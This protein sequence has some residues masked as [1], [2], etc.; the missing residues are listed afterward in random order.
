MHNRH[1]LTRPAAVAFATALALVAVTAVAWDLDQDLSTADGALI[2]ESGSDEAGFHVVL[3]GDLDG[4]GYADLVIAA[5]AAEGID[6]N[7][8]RV[9]VYLGAVGAWAQA[10]DIGDADASFLGENYNDRA[11]H[12]L[13]YAGDVNGDGYDDLLI[14]A[15]FNDEA[16]NSFGQAYLILGDPAGWALDTDLG[17]AD[18][19][20]HG[21]ANSDNAGEAVAG[22]GDVDG[23]GHD[24]LLIAAPS[25][26]VAYG[27]Q[28]KVYLVTGRASGW[29]D[30]RD[31]GSYADAS[32]YGEADGDYA[33]ISL[34]SAGDV[35][36]D[37]YDDVLIGAYWNDE[38][39]SYA[40]QV[41]L[42]LGSAAGFSGTTNLEYSD[43]SFLGENPD[44]EAGTAVAGAGDV[45]SD[46]YDD[47]LIGAPGAS[48]AG[49]DAGEAY[50][51][52]GHA[53]GWSMDTDLSLADASFT[54]EA[55]DD[56][57]GTD[58]AA[59][60]DTNLDGHD[61]FLVG[62]PWN[63]ENGSGAGQVY[64]LLGR[65]GSWTLH[66]DLAAEAE[67]TWL[68]ELAGDQAGT[69]VGGNGDVDAD[70][71]PDVA[72]GAPYADINGHYS[73]TAYLALTATCNDADGDGYGDPGSP[74]CPAG[75][76]DDCDD[77]D[78]AVNPSAVEIA[79]DFID[80]DCDGALHWDEI[81]HDADGCVDCD[82]DCCAGPL[83]PNCQETPCDYI[84]ND[85]DGFLHPYE[86][87][88]DGDGHDECMGD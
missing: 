6:A 59:A 10:V 79:C 39:G 37:G 71:H 33:G 67:A 74:T 21:E 58:V 12:G 83:D 88:D 3:D 5:E 63:D 40:G 34:D 50:L 35:D 47:F 8:G 87:D 26:D 14:G 43:A 51:V 54:G 46:G 23:D 86:T 55:I 62:A 53:L 18:A 78:P 72:I 30:D 32:F 1:P 81:D 66:A 27:A 49:D 13:S 42:L 68:G 31:L 84:D 19:S 57:A 45:N 4:D 61:D 60:G 73:G 17:D 38:G 65:A 56:F 16:G 29:Q 11:G 76:E 52:L 22:A 7:A 48:Y 85:G 2:G 75:D 24:D 82:E 70:G 9:Y 77:T 25:A 69:S 28:G 20:F 15:P 36:G 44:D 41:Y 80:N 64:L